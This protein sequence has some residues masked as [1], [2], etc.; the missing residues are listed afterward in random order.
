MVLV[1]LMLTSSSVLAKSNIMRMVDEVIADYFDDDDLR[2]EYE[3]EIH[4]NKDG[5]YTLNYDDMTMRFM[6]E[7]KGKPDKNGKY[8]L[9]I[10]LHGG[11]GTSSANNDSQWQQMFSYYKGSVKNGIYIACR[12][13]TDT[14]DLHFQEKSY[15]LYD[16]LIQNMIYTHDADPNR[17]YLLGFSAGGDGVYQI[18]P[19]MADR[20]AAGNMSSG[21]PNRVSLLNLANC[22][23]SIQAGIRD[24]YSRSAMRSVRA[25]EFEKILTE[26]SEYYDLGYEHRV[27][28][29]VPAGH[30]YPDNKASAKSYVLEDPMKFA[31]QGEKMLDDFISALG[32]Y[33]DDD[34][35]KVSAVSYSPLTDDS[36]N[37]AIRDIV[38]RKYKL[39][40][41][42]VTPDAVAYVSQFRR[43]PLP[44][45]I[46]WDLST[47]AD[48][49]ET[50]SF[51]W[52]QADILTYEGVIT[53]SINRATNTISVYPENVNGDFSILI[54]PYMIDVSKPVNFVTSDGEYSATIEPSREMIEE[55]LEDRGDPNYV[56]VGKISYS[57]LKNMRRKK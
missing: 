47:R 40:V 4:R 54:S 27:L 51:Y 23:I 29:H 11:G 18:L 7:R 35:K 44:E 13:I 41:K 39:K 8:P 36:F 1:S 38:T 28:I 57:E 6:M 9:Y 16:R 37:R 55:S 32:D 31:A 52:L 56:Y 49:R 21:H 14:W 10:T 34:A 15:P 42:Q 5:S 53:A 17:V 19:R 24:Y 48:E 30:N 46:V 33:R 43:N 50:D 26:Y 12:G 3:S 20:F 25:A 22:P 45:K 2:A